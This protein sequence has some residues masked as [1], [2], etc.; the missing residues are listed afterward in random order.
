M[1]QVLLWRSDQFARAITE[2]LFTYALGH[3]LS[4]GE[5]LV[6]DDMAAVVMERDLG[7][8][9]LIVA[10]CSSPLFLGEFGAAAVEVDV[11]QN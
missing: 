9:D 1:K 3:P 7:L 8:Q 10:I 4:V 2:K 5:R 11:A 6:A